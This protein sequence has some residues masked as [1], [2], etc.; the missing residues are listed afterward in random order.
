MFGKIT[1]NV[2]GLGEGGEKKA[3]KFKIVKMKVESNNVEGSTKAPLLPNPCWWL[4]PFQ[5][6][7]LKIKICQKLK[8]VKQSLKAK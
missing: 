1:A 2:F 6:H 8:K 4:V 7:N 3:L 5:V